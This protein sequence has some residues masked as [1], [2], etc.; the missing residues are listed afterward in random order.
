MAPNSIT[1]FTRRDLFDHF[2]LS[3]FDWSGRMSESEFLER[4]FSISKL[5]SDDHR[6]RNMLGDVALHRE[7]FNDWG[8][9]DWL[10]TDRRLALLSCPDEQLLRFLAETIHPL[11][12]PDQNQVDELLSQ[13]NVYLERDGYRLEVTSVISGKR[14][15]SGAST[16]LDDSGAT[17]RAQKVADLL[18]SDHV[19]GQITRMRTSIQTDPALAIGSAKEFVE[20]ITKTILKERGV[21]VSGAETLPGL[22]KLVRQELILDLEPAAGEALKRTLSGLSAVTQ[23]L[24]EL[25]GRLGT[26][27]GADPSAPKPPVEVARLAVGL[28]TT[29]GVFLYEHHQNLLAA[30][31]AALALCEDKP[32]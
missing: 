32:I 25:R 30:Q 26:G 14:I 3:G 2:R 19:S 16:A 18:A 21:E 4:V 17:E 31:S 28:A 9:P 11:V 13:I 29:L 7:N 6:A 15:F 8:G 23:G 22:V 10:Y 1:D 24:A 5:P 20:S 12:R 27:H